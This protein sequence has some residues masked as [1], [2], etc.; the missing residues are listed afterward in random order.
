MPPSTT[1]L[2]SLFLSTLLTRTFAAPPAT[3]PF[4]DTT[5]FLI[6]SSSSGASAQSIS[7]STS[8]ATCPGL[9]STTRKYDL[10]AEPGPHCTYQSWISIFSTPT[11]KSTGI[12]ACKDHCNADPACRS[13]IWFL[14]SATPDQGTCELSYNFYDS[15][16]VHCEDPSNTNTYLAVYNA[17]NWKSPNPLVPNGD[18]ETGCLDPWFFTD[19]T[20]DESM[21][22]DVVKCNQN[23][24]APNGG[25]F[26]VRVTGH[27]AKGSE[28]DHIDAYIGQQPA[29][30]EGVR[31]RLT[32]QVKGESGE[33]RF[34]YP[35]HKSVVI[36]A[37]ATKEWKEVKGEFTGHVSSFFLSLHGSLSLC[38][39]RA[40]LLILS[41]V[42]R[43]LG[44]S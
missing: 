27:G 23:N 19:F 18:F 26:F 11:K 15:T 8:S 41:C 37:N 31:Y 6:L 29:L 1:V 16:V 38:K 25:K 4:Y 9:P 43:M 32:A 30:S 33:F 42:S 10:V 5:P 40:P 2:T 39:S 3:D 34:T 44:R 13:F 36:R 12:A 24:C 14:D 28:R 21:R 22:A 20:S 17:S 35:A 7:P